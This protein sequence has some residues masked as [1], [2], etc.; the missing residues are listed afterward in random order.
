M[1]IPPALL[2]P[3]DSLPSLV[4]STFASAVE[5]DQVSVFEASSSSKHSGSGA[6]D[7][8]VFVCP[9]LDEKPGAPH[10]T[11]DL[12]SPKD[13]DPFKGPS[14]PEGQSIADLGDHVALNNTNAMRD[15]TFA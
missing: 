2:P 15:R 12:S 11:P 5:K 3:L 8:V 7:H 1:P 4:A 9:E 6:F 10:K 13:K 14:F